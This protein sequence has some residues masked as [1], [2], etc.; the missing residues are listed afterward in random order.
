MLSDKIWITRKTRIYTEQRLIKMNT[1]SNILVVWYSSI[2][3]CLTIWN[4]QFPNNKLNIYLVFGSI[5]VLIASIVLT[6]Q[7]YSERSIAMRNCYIKLDELYSKVKN[8]EGK[9]DNISIRDFE[10]EYSGIIQNIE[11]HSDYDYLCLRFSLRNRK[12]TTLPD[13]LI[14]NWASYILGKIWRIFVDIFLFV[15]PLVAAYFWGFI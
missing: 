12:D 5:A 2:L 7:K 6:S 14:S 15:L 8:A 10:S 13:F 4:L 11:N 9:S 1:I 3:V